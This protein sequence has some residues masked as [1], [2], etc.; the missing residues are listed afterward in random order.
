MLL[1]GSVAQSLT[2]IRDIARPLGE[3]TNQLVG[4]GLV[5]GLNGTGDGDSLATKRPM[6]EMLQKL[7][8]PVDIN[9]ITAKNVAYV[10]ISARIGRNGARSGDL[11]DV[12]VSSANGA[13][14]LAGGRLIAS[15]LQSSSPENDDMIA[16]AEGLISVPNEDY[17][18]SGVIYGGAVIEDD[19]LYTYVTPYEQIGQGGYFTLVLDDEHADFQVARTVAME[20]ESEFS[21]PGDLPTNTG[22]NLPEVY[23]QDPKNLQITIPESQ[24]DNAPLLIA[25]ILDLQ[26]ELPLPEAKVVID[27]RSQTIAITGTVEIAPVSVMVGGVTIQ[28]T[29]PGDGTGD[30]AGGT[31]PE[32]AGTTLR[33]LI[34][35][36]DQINIPIEQKMEAIYSI[37]RANCLLARLETKG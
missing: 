6:M 31:G 27:R 11:I 24:M 20:I 17:P 1:S 25:R 3:R 7:G 23:F 9:D 19:I 12:Q 2:R 22:L 37:Q 33:Q 36:M 5:V 21:P 34:A 4:V 14:S 32:T 28:I 10:S 30:A 15:P 26:L 18:T 8:N 29:E 16:M 35:A 13:K